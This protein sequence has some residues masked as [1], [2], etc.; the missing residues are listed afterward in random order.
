M[1]ANELF[2]DASYAIALAASSD[3][4]HRRAIEL[5]DDIERAIRKK[6]EQLTERLIAVP[7]AL[8]SI[9]QN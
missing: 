5:A 1:V 8:R 4:L 9:F 2:L 3:Q 7:D 6:L